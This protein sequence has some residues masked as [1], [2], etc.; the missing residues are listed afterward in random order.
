MNLLPGIHL[1]VYSKCRIL[2]SNLE[3]LN[4]NSHFYKIPASDYALKFIKHYSTKK[5]VILSVR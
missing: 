4:L 1:G 2:D 5:V 3:L